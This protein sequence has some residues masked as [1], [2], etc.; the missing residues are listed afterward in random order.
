MALEHF[1]VEKGASYPILISEYLELSFMVIPY[2]AHGQFLHTE[3][4]TVWYG[5]SVSF[6]SFFI[7][8]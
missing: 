1:V 6:H 4:V 5:F 2:V 7:I 3:Y 8:F